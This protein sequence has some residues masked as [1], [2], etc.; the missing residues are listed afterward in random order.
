MARFDDGSAG[1]ADYGPHRPRLREH[2]AARSAHRGGRVEGT[3]RREQRDQRRRRRRSYEPPRP[4]VDRRRALGVDARGAPA[5]RVRAID[6][7]ADALP[8]DD[9]SFDAAMASVTIHQWPDP[10]RGLGEMRRVARGPVVI[11]TFTPPAAGTVVAARY[12][13]ELFDVEAAACPSS[14]A[15]PPLWAAPSEVRVVPIPRTAST[16]SG[17]RSSPVPSAPWNPRYG[18]PC[19]RGASSTRR[20]SPRYERDSAPI[21]HPVPG[22]PLGRFPRAGVLR[23]RPAPGGRP[24]VTASPPAASRVAA[25][26]ILD[27][28]PLLRSRRSRGLLAVQAQDFAG[29]MWSLGCAARVDRRDVEAA[30]A[31]GEIVRSWPMRGTLHFV[32]PED[33]GWMLSLTASAWSARPGVTVRLGLRPPTSCPP[34]RLR[35]AHGWGRP[36]PR[37]AVARSRRRR[38]L[39]RRQRGVHILRPVPVG[40]AGVGS[41]E[42]ELAAARRV[43]DGAARSSSATTRSREFALRYFARPRP[44]HDARLRLVVVAHPRR[45]ARRARRRARRARRARDRRQD[46]TSCAP[47]LEPPARPCT[48]S[49]DSTSSA[50]L[51]R[52]Q[53]A[54]APNTDDDRSG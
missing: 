28:M 21:L 2:P 27:R 45:R 54:L 7:T 31:T 46:A 52:P 37:R 17:R 25:L 20:W 33:L 41:A 11:L 1:D 35:G 19:R 34:R 36:H 38:G 23:R 4:R 43:G 29:A 24:A 32:A 26:G 42:G 47:G 50:R 3:R 10:E 44:G 16:D 13:P 49:P 5:D 40:R 39:A 30:L 9:D 12:V 51:P 48:C 18:G 8:F 53:R 15:S 14:I 22:T 6:A